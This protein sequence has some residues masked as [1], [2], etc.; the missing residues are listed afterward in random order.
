MYQSIYY[1]YKDYKIYLRDDKKG[2]STHDYK[3][4]YYNRVEEYVEGAYPVLTGGYAIPTNKLDKNNPNQL[5]RDINKE[6]AFLRDN[7][8][9]NDEDIPE[10]HNILYLDIEIEMGGA[11]TVQY[12]RDSPKPITSISLIDST[13]NSKICLVVSAD[14]NVLTKESVTIIQCKTEKEL[15]YKFLDKFRELD[16]TI[17]V[18]WNGEYFDIPYLYFRILKTCGEEAASKLSPIGEINVQTYNPTINMVRLAGINH[19]DYMLLFKKYITKQE[20]SYKLGLIGEKYVNLGKIEYEG[21][22]DQLFKNDIDKFIEYN[23]R[24]VEIIEAL[25][26]QQKFIE[27]TILISHICNVPY[28]QVYFST[29]LGEGAILKHLKRLNIVS[30][31]KPTTHNSYL[32]TQDESYAGG[33]LLEPEPGIYKDVIDLDFTSLYPSIIKSLNLGIETLVGRIY[34]RNNYEQE[35]SLDYLLKLPQ[36]ETI[37]IERLN[38]TNYT[39]ESSETTVGNIVD[40]IKENNFT[41]SSSGAIYRTDTRSAASTVLE[42]WFNKREYYRKLKKEAGKNKEWDKYKLYDL[43]QYAFKILQ[44]GHYGTYAKSG[45]RYT[46]GFLICS[47]AITNTGQVL[48]K[49]SIDFVNNELKNKYDKI[50]VGNYI[51]I[52]DTDSLYIHL[53][54]IIEHLNLTENKNQ[55]ILKIAYEIQES[56]N[57]NLNSLCEKTFNIQPNTH[58]FQLKQEVIDFIQSDGITIVLCDGGWKI[59]EFNL[60]SDYIKSGDFILA[61]DFSNSREIYENEIKNKIWN[62]CE[63]TEDDIKDAVNKHNLKSY[64][65]GLFSQAVWVCKYK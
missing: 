1:N 34:T 2:W 61:H 22:L 4:T 48:T 36:D 27:L 53:H 18:T 33:Y 54:P 47:C 56:A 44:N 32:K 11:L 15:I 65:Q 62:W 39:L 9:K 38:K 51:I 6:L 50:N 60:L 31:N 23:I 40:I 57:H 25:E 55:A 29:I 58:Y 64:N 21:N 17:L 13:T 35:K 20:P 8:Y 30:P 63:I 19:L 45:F 49:K 12:I 37:R 7:Y 10:W 14:N 5:E 42:Y 3:P 59:G 41:I 52:S 16:P 26:K 46:D 28:E 24:D 43:Y